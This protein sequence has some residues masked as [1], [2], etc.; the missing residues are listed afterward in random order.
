MGSLNEQLARYF[1]ALRPRY[2]TAILSNSFVGAREREQHAYGFAEICDVVVYSHEEGTKKPDASIY[3]IVCDRLGVSA[4]N[5]L[6]LDDADPC[7]EGAR[8]IGMTAI[9]FTDT[10]QGDSCP[11]LAPRLATRVGRRGPRLASAS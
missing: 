3:R 10:D 7:V 1:A 5:A 9:R 2:R 8:Q 6:F 4:Q 11:R